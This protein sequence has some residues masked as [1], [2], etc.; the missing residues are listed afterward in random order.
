MEKEIQTIPQD[1]E[2]LRQ[3]DTLLEDENVLPSIRKRYVILQALMQQKTVEEI[4]AS[5][6]CVK[7]TVEKVRKD[8]LEKGLEG[9]IGKK[10]GGPTP[11]YERTYTCSLGLTGGDPSLVEL[12]ISDL[13]RVAV[14]RTDAK[15][16]FQDTGMGSITARG[17]AMVQAMDELAEEGPIQLCDALEQME[18]SKYKG[19]DAWHQQHLHTRISDFRQEHEG[20]RFIQNFLFLIYGR[21]DGVDRLDREL[22][23][24][25]GYAYEDFHFALEWTN[26]VKEL[27]AHK[28]AEKGQLKDVLDELMKAVQS[29]VVYHKPETLPFLWKADKAEAVGEKSG[30][31][32][33]PTAVSQTVDA[34]TRIA[35]LKMR[36]EIPDMNPGD[37]ILILNAMI[38]NRKGDRITSYNVSS[39]GKL[40]TEQRRDLSG[41]TRIENYVGQISKV[42][43]NLQGDVNHKLIQYFFQEGIKNILADGL[44]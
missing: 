6:G 37:S 29:Y 8:Y 2:V 19:T 39:T 25:S 20:Q 41:I 32:T 15:F 35:D 22:L 36:M 28:Q 11:V 40:P 14:F 13:Y 17:K 23:E 33:D 1:P 7:A 26:R 43:E 38:L 10:R 16:I 24:R 5:T 18:D 3:L 42:L 31:K 12:Y 9:M 34:G 27:L 30:A 44:A 21:Y 4:M